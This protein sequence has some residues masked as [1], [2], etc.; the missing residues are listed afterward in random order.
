MDGLLDILRQDKH[1]HNEEARK[2]LLG[3]FEVL[4]PNHPL[5]LQYRQELALV[6]F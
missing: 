1:Y 3:L 4:G 5:T 6:L 2:V